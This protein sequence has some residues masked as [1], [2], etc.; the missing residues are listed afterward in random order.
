MGASSIGR[1]QHPGS[2]AAHKLL[3]LQPFQPLC[4]RRTP[5]GSWAPLGGLGQGPGLGP[6]RKGVCSHSPVQARPRCVNPCLPGVTGMERL[7]PAPQLALWLCGPVLGGEES[8]DALPLRPQ[9]CQAQPC[10]PRPLVLAFVCSQA[11]GA[12]RGSS[13]WAPIPGQ[14][15]APPPTSLG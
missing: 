4:G 6:E 9:P 10:S 2:F 14:H 11:V 15:P 5:L 13:R 1:P 8:T 7:T 3:L 12:G